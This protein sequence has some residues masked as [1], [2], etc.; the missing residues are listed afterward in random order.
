MKEDKMGRACSK[1]GRSEKYIQTLL[2]NQKE[3][4]HF[5]DLGFDGRMLLKLI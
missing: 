4:Y 5:E 1:H 2:E 3:K